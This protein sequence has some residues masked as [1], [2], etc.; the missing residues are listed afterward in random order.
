MPV[1][2]V[3]KTLVVFKNIITSDVIIIGGGGLF[4]SGFN[5]RI[6]FTVNMAYLFRKKIVL[7]GVGID[8]INVL[9]YSK[10][11]KMLSKT[12][13]ITVRDSYYKKNLLKVNN[14]SKINKMADIL[15]LNKYQGNFRKDEFILISLAMPF[16][17]DEMR[18]E[19][20]KNRY[21]L[22]IESIT[23]LINKMKLI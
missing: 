8:T 3:L 2:K 15:F 11:N 7:F 9:H 20:F 19:K 18:I 13:L 12:N 17:D 22:F 1:N 5:K 16:T 23:Y 14:S 4:P 6:Y 10:W 21:R